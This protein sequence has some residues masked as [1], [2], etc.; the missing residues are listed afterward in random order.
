SAA[1]AQTYSNPP[2][3]A[4]GAAPMRDVGSP[5]ANANSTATGGTQ[6]TTVLS[7]SNKRQSAEGMPSSNYDQS[8]QGGYPSQAQA[9][10]GSQDLHQSARQLDVRLRA[11]ARAQRPRDVPAARQGAGRNQLHQ[12]HGLHARQRRRL[13]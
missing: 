11:G 3:G 1:L 2:Y 8:M 9:P 12:R 6:S 10:Y 4:G 5:S 7:Q 13:R